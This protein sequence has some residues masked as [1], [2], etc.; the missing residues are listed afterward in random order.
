M[1]VNNMVNSQIISIY[2]KILLF[3]SFGLV[4]STITLAKQSFDDKD[5]RNLGTHT[6]LKIESNNL[7]MTKKGLESIQE[8]GSSIVWKKTKKHLIIVTA[9]H[10]LKGTKKF[11]VLIPKQSQNYIPSSNLEVYAK[12]NY[13][14]VFIRLELTKEIKDKYP[15]ISELKSVENDENNCSSDIKSGRAFGFPKFYKGQTIYDPKV[16]LGRSDINGYEIKYLKDNA[17][18]RILHLTLDPTDKGMSGGPVFDNMGCFRGMV[19]GRLPD[20]LGVAVHYEDISS[21]YDNDVEFYKFNSEDFTKDTVFSKSV[22]HSFSSDEEAVVNDISWRNAQHWGELFD[23][24]SVFRRQFKDI[25]INLEHYRLKNENNTNTQLNLRKIGYDKGEINLTINGEEVKFS[26]SINLNQYLC[27]GQNQIL[28]FNRSRKNKHQVF[29]NDIFRSNRL[30]LVLELNDRRIYRIKREF[31]EILHESYFLILYLNV[32]PDILPSCKLENNN[33]QIAFHVKSL[34]KKLYNTPVR[35]PIFLQKKQNDAQQLKYHVEGCLTLE[36]QSKEKQKNNPLYKIVNARSRC[37]SVCVDKEFNYVDFGFFGKLD[38]KKAIANTGF[39][40]AQLFNQTDENAER[41]TCSKTN[42]QINTNNS[43]EFRFPLY[44]GTRLEFLN[45]V[46]THE[47]GWMLRGT[48]ADFLANSAWIHVGCGAYIFPDEKDFFINMTPYL[49]DILMLWMNNH[50]NTGRKLKVFSEYYLENSF[51]WIKSNNPN[52]IHSRVNFVSHQN[53]DWLLVDFKIKG[54]SSN[55]Q[56]LNVLKTDFVSEH[57][58]ANSNNQND[59]DIFIEF[60]NVTT[61]YKEMGIFDTDFFDNIGLNGSL[62]LSLKI[63]LTLDSLAEIDVKSDYCDDHNNDIKIN[64]IYEK[65]LIEL[66]KRPDAQI[67]FAFDSNLTDGPLFK[68]KTGIIVHGGHI[69]GKGTATLHREDKTAEDYDN[70]SVKLQDIK[71]SVDSLTSD[72]FKL[73]NATFS[74]PSLN[75]SK[76]KTKSITTAKGK[77]ENGTI[78]LNGF[79]RKIPHGLEFTI[80]LDK[81]GEDFIQLESIPLSF[82]LPQGKFQLNLQPIKLMLL[83]DGTVTLKQAIQPVTINSSSPKPQA[84]ITLPKAER[85]FLPLSLTIPVSTVREIANS[86]LPPEFKQ[87]GIDLDCSVGN[88]SMDLVVKR[89]GEISLDVSGQKLNS[90][91]P[92][93]VDVRIKWWQCINLGFRNVCTSHKEYPSGDID[94]YINTPLSL[95]KN[96]RIKSESKLNSHINRANLGNLGK[97]IRILNKLGAHIDINKQIQRLIH[98]ELNKLASRIDNEISKINIKTE[99]MP[100]WN[101]LQTPRKLI[102]NPPLWLNLQLDKVYFAGL[103][104]SGEKIKLDLAVGGKIQGQ[105]SNTSIPMTS[106]QLPALIELNQNLPKYFNINMPLAV[107]FDE[108]KKQFKSHLKK[109]FQITQELDASLQL[110]NVYGNGNKLVTQVGFTVFQNNIALVEGNISII[111]QVDWNHNQQQLEIKQFEIMIDNTTDQNHALLLK[112]LVASINLEENHLVFPLRKEIKQAKHALQQAIN[113]RILSHRQIGN[114]YLQGK[115]KNLKIKDVFVQKKQVLI[116]LKTTGQVE[117]KN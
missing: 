78:E 26:R 81:Q 34:H 5:L 36:P 67:E 114:F 49:P 4:S 104:G 98:P 40:E 9:Y 85:S 52:S 105:I 73:E 112:Q 77:I 47:S 94:V 86:A 83:Q 101:K 31:P 45:K 108:L 116:L 25:R 70:I 58:K 16:T 65:I 46:K 19:I 84:E 6:T 66:F 29:L 95:E 117:I 37:E 75:L 28:I 21:I 56:T 11:K 48:T 57:L 79:R 20:I 91:V 63:A 90:K 42:Q 38:I 92:L 8:Y 61:T 113:R 17:L 89:Q 72:Q 103:E 109:R 51:S 39:F 3:L 32:P 100:I 10:V 50:I 27:P 44:Y 115:V 15:W 24:P 87:N 60:S 82:D 35:L 96:W 43:K 2:I 62:N 12:P 33:A 59:P 14:L 107:N 23:D 69:T 22:E 76:D 53:K 7:K 18:M 1:F 64:E 97:I 54:S 102:N 55:Q 80:N 88:C 30:N 68:N 110:Q 99:L 111:G 13:D 71:I 93:F 74:I 106:M 41:A